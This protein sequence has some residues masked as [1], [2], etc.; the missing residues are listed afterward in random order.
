[1]VK[2][3]LQI[4]NNNKAFRSIRCYV[5]IIYIWFWSLIIMRLNSHTTQSIL[6][7]NRFPQGPKANYGFVAV[8]PQFRAPE[9]G[10]Y[11]TFDY[12]YFLSPVSPKANLIAG[13]SGRV[14]FST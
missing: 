11:T 6:L 13:K 10:E 3:L 2:N 9:S 4:V 14:K 1:M 7:D 5:Q 8:S 12:E